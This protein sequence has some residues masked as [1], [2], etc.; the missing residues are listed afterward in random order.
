VVAAAVPI[1]VGSATATTWAT[2]LGAST[3]PL[4]SASAAAFLGAV[5]RYGH[6]AITV[7]TGG[8]AAIAATA[9]G[10]AGIAIGRSGGAT[11]RV[12]VGLPLVSGGP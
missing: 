5:P 9:S 12:V 11:L 1:A 4:P 6:A 10:D 8:H 7:T 2:A 3:V